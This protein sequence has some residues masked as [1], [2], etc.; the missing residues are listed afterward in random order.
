[1]ASGGAPCVI[2]PSFV[3]RPFFIRN[4]LVMHFWAYQK[5]MTRGQ[6]KKGPRGPHTRT[7]QKKKKVLPQ[8]DSATRKGQK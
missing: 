1:M 4:L 8:H 7:P 6:E 5:R 2:W 3:V